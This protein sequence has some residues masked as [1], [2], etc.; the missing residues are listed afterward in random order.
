MICHAGLDPASRNA[1]DSGLRRNDG[2]S[3][4]TETVNMSNE[5]LGAQA[6]SVKGLKDPL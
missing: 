6:L 5:K 1:L 4:N 2:V 3:D